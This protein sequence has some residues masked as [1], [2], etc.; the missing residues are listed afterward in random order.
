M[1][2]SIQRGIVYDS[3]KEKISEKN[4]LAITLL[5]GDIPTEDFRAYFNRMFQQDANIKAMVVFNRS[6]DKIISRYKNDLKPEFFVLPQEIKYTSDIK[7]ADYLLREQIAIKDDQKDKE[8]YIEL[9]EDFMKNNEL[10]DGI[11]RIISPAGRKAGQVSFVTVFFYDV[12]NILNANYYMVKKIIVGTAILAIIHLFMTIFFYFHYISKPLKNFISV[13]RNIT[14]GRFKQKVRYYRNDEFGEFVLNFNNMID[15]LWASRLEDRLAHPSTGLPT[16]ASIAEKVDSVIKQEEGAQIAYFYVKNQDDYI[17]KYGASY[18]EN[19]MGFVTQTIFNIA[20]EK[21]PEFYLAH[22][23][24]SIFLGI[25]SAFDISE[26]CRN[27]II[28]F[29]TKVGDFLESSSIKEIPDKKLFLKIVCR[30]IDQE[31]EI[32]SYK[33]LEKDVNDLKDKFAD[34]SD[35]CF[36]SKLSDEIFA[37]SVNQLLS[38]EE[39]TPWVDS[40]SIEESEETDEEPKEPDT[41]TETEE[42]EEQ[43]LEPEAEEPEAEEP[44]A[45]EPEAEEPEAEEPEAEEP[46]AEEPEA[47]EPEAEEPEAEEPEAEEPEAE[48]PEAEEP[49][50]EEPEAE[51]PEAE[52]PEAEEPETE[53]PET[54][55]PE[56]EEPEAEEPEAEEPEAEEP[57]AEEPEAEESV[58]E[59]TPEKQAEIDEM[60]K[61]LEE[62]AQVS[63]EIQQDESEVASQ[64]S[65]DEESEPQTDLEE[66]DDID[67]AIK[68]ATN[69]INQEIDE[70]V[71]MTDD[72]LKEM[73]G[74]DSEDKV[75]EAIKRDDI[76]SDDEIKDLLGE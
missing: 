35:I 29:E 38:D 25:T 68:E 14:R 41:S 64:E 57:E 36:I 60:N 75:E 6:M 23:T 73:I 33:E 15:F 31:T 39:P 70:T 62:A 71:M 44:E 9:Y 59:I 67:E 48:E 58:E 8:H 54:E 11:I 66:D 26:I 1:V 7:P 24:D 21:D 30:N 45:E 53:E 65:G 3:F 13:A 20:Y 46:E 4:Q 72:Q 40:E 49:E 2:F 55:E 37:L 76:L 12:S 47:E 50:A 61:L 42:S 22:V 18:G 43:S 32:N 63:E 52:E 10:S 34:K 74:E 27:I 69:L 19:I 56:A 17:H 16:S 5:K 28:D 51:E